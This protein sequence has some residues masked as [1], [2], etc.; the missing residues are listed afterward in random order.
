MEDTHLNV[1]G[2]YL[3]VFLGY[4]SLLPAIQERIGILQRTSTLEPLKACID[5]F[6]CHHKKVDDLF[7]DEGVQNPQNGLTERLQQLVYFLKDL[8][9]A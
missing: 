7:R 1:A 8:N 5:E 9:D 6:L 4:L 3:A 2:G